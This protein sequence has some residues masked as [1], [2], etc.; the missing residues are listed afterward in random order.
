MLLKNITE[1][2]IKIDMQSLFLAYYAIGGAFTMK[3]QFQSSKLNS[4]SVII[5]FNNN[6]F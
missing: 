1:K 4:I 3:I 5:Q 2:Y 6:N